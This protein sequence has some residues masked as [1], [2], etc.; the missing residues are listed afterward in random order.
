ML[1]GPQIAAKVRNLRLKKGPSTT[2]LGEELG[3]SKTARRQI[4]SK[5]FTSFLEN[6]D[7]GRLI[8]PDLKKLAKYYDLPEY[9]FLFENHE[10]IAE[11]KNILHRLVDEAVD[12]L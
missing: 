3:A 2:K 8:I 1:D 12:Q 11:V 7:K 4:K 9:W 6:L 10:H 5:R